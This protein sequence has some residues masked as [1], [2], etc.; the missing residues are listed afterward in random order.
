MSA[1]GVLRAVAT[2]VFVVQV[3]VLLDVFFSLLLCL[4]GHLCESV[5]GGV[6]RFFG[7]R[8]FP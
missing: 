1:C 5:R 4:A 7:A 8:A 6:R 3:V 2:V